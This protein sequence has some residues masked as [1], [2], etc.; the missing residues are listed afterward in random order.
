M[1]HRSRTELA[2][3]KLSNWKDKEISRCLHNGSRN[4]NFDSFR[5]S[6][7]NKFDRLIIFDLKEK[8]ISRT[9]L[10]RKKLSK[11]KHNGEEF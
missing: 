11:C 5:R 7:Q 2:N 10:V 3:R 6:I 1:K 8:L 9:Q 4:M